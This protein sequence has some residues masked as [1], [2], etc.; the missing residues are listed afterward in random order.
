MLKFITLFLLSSLCLLAAT[1][2]LYKPIGDPIY[3][4]IPA[5][6]SLSKMTYFLNDKTFLVNFVQEANQHKKLGFS[7]DKKRRNKTLSKEEQKNYLDGL[8][9][10]KKQMQ[11]IYGLVREALPVII[12]KNYVK[13]YYRLKKTKLDILFLDPKSVSIMKKFE[14]K[15]NAKRRAQ[16][17]QR[18]LKEKNDKVNHYNFIRSNKNLAG[19]WKGKGSDNNIMSATFIN[20]IIYLTYHNDKETTV[21]KGKFSIIKNDFHFYIQQRKRTKSDISHIKKVNFERTYKII[22]ISEKELFLTHKDEVIKLYR[23]LGKSTKK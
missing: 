1:P 3:N 14:K 9:S 20:D 4:E 11:H 12:K 19:K 13:T 10:L 17:K 21:F 6:I 16:E 23:K 8:R 15:V 7:Y 18:A 5:V 22:S 2:R